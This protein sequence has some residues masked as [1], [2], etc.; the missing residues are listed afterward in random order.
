M[1]ATSETAS[2][3]PASSAAILRSLILMNAC[4]LQ[5]TSVFVGRSQNG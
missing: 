1:T 5:V 4:I 2:A 3:F